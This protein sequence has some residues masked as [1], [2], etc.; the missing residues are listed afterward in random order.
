MTNGHST[1]AAMLLAGKPLVLLPQH[2]EMLLIAR[3][4]EEHGAG[5]SAPLLKLEGILGKLER[6]L[7]EPQFRDKAQALAA[8]HQGWDPASPVNN[9]QALV[10]R[11]LAER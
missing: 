8:S 9:F 1:T 2:L 6:V 7:M 11:L 5:L 4:V 3:S 10:T